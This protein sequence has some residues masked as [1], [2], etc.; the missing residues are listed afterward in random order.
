MKERKEMKFT[1]KQTETIKEAL[2]YAILYHEGL[3]EAHTDHYSKKP[4]LGQ[5]EF[6]QGFEALIKRYVSL[7]K[8]LSVKK[9]I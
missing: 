9:N 6:V 8:K 4:M 5:E 1:E 7:L 3:I 2:K